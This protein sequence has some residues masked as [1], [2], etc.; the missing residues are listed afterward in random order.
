MRTAPTATYCQYGLT[1]MGT[2]P[3]W[4]TA[5]TSRPM[6]VPVTV[7]LP[8]NRLAPPSTTAAIADRLSAVWPLIVVVLKCASDRQPAVPASSPD[9][10]YTVIRCRSTEMPA[11]RG[12]PAVGAVA[13]VCCPHPGDAGNSPGTAPQNNATP[14]TP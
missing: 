6:T 12:A 8:P 14:P 4:R 3:L 1:W 9:R 13:D 10:P 11:R 5:G 7:P 2:K